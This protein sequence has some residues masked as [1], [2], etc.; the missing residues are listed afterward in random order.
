LKKKTGFLQLL[1][2]ELQLLP[3]ACI[4]LTGSLCCSTC[5]F[6]MENFKKT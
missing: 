2:M 1:A 6:I 4:S 5:L 3:L